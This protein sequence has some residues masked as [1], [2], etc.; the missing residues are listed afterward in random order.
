MK[1]I[2]FTLCLMFG[3][4][5]GMS[6][7]N[8]E[9]AK[10]YNDY[11]V[12]MQTAI[13]DKNIEYATNSVHNNN[14]AEVDAKRLEVI[15]LTVSSIEKV[16][17]LPAFKGDAKL[18]DEAANV[19]DLYLQTYNIDYSEV[20]T[21]KKDRESSYE[22]MEAYFAAEEKAAKKLEDAGDKFAKAQQSFAERNGM[23]LA[24]GKGSD[25]RAMLLDAIAE[26]NAYQKKMF[27]IQFKILKLNAAFF[28]A[29]DAKKEKAA[30]KVRK[31]IIEACE[32]AFVD[33]KAIGGYKADREYYNKTKEYVHAVKGLA[34]RDLVAIVDVV[35]TGESNLTEKQV[36]AYNEAIKAYNEV[37][38]NMGNE[39]NVVASDFLKRNTPKIPEKGM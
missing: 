29:V 2:N 38:V 30:E 1:K 5:V 36:N 19:F 3:A 9:D 7:Q 18:R 35:K 23:R 24:A 22:A 14:V 13:S 28:D 16:K 26:T 37:S 27:L 31:E 11:I 8:F 21:L 20:L 6:A 12:S 32:K 34:N 17:A 15:A 39:L 33:L 4:V 10:D 25:D